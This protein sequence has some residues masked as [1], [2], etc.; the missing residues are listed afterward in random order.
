[1]TYLTDLSI[2]AAMEQDGLVIS[3]LN[4]DAL[5]PASVDVTLG[6]TLI[7]RTLGAIVDP[8]VDQSVCWEDVPFGGDRWLL[9]PHQLYLGALAEYVEIPDDMLA[10]L[11]GRSTLARC[12]ISIHQQAGLLDPG[13]HGCATV[14][15]TVIYPTWLRPGDPIGQLVFAKCQTAA[16]RPYGHYR[17]HSKYQGDRRP[18]PAWPFTREATMP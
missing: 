6:P 16:L 10:F 2:R 7:R 9:Q 11:H 8:S 13:Y 18:T 17:L 1:M 12:G 14:E 15:L 4:P 3:P 5:Q